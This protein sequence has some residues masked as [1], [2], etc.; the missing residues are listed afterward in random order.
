[1]KAKYKLIALASFTLAFAGLAVGVPLGVSAEG[2]DEAVQSGGGEEEAVVTTLGE[3]TTALK[4]S[5]RPVVKLGADIELDS[6]ILINGGR[7]V[8]IDLNGH[9]ITTNSTADLIAIYNAQV[10]V[11]GT[12]T[13]GSDTTASPFYVA[14]TNTDVA[15]FSKLTVGENVTLKADDYAIWVGKGIGSFT[16]VYGASIDFYGKID[17]KYGFYINGTIQ[18][19]DGNVA[20]FNIHDGAEIKTT[21]HYTYAAGYGHWTFDK[22]TIVAGEG[23]GLKAGTFEYNGTTVTTTG[24]YA[25]PQSWNNGINNSGAT[26]QIESNDAYADNVK[27]VVNGGTYISQNGHVFYEYK[28]KEDTK[29]TVREVVIK[30][31]EFVAGDNR[32]VF[33]VSDGF[34]LTKFI[35]GGVFSDEPAED[36]IADGYVAVLEKDNFE[37]INPD[38]LDPADEI[39]TTVVDG[40]EVNIVVP[41][42]IDWSGE[43]AIFSD[44]A[45]EDSVSGRVVFAD[46]MVADRLA[47]IVILD[48]SD[49]VDD[50]TVDATKTGDLIKAFDVSMIDRN[51][52]EIEVKDNTIRVYIDLTEDEYSALAAYN[53]V[54]V[55][56]FDDD[57][58]EAERLDAEIYEE[59]DASG[60]STYVLAFTTSHFSTYGV[61][62][63]NASEDDS[64][65]TTTVDTPDTGTVTASGASAMNASIVA[66]V[67]VGLITTVFGLA[68][69]FKRARE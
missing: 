12:G 61:V 34:S 36:Y 28:A 8:E 60:V 69:V 25:E 67:A 29:N 56:Y 18:N 23:I 7:I 40:E 30:D 16:S 44:I 41:K 6:R 37:V 63:V 49:E 46:E 15:D 9:N 14:A 65:E 43:S 59:T 4:D 35:S 3:F 2:S 39:I 1:M 17:S 47:R 53:K 57:G 19:T 20:T 64:T 68:V 21:G 22:A 10:T 5:T 13:I 55:V 52:A 50:L 66:A 11:S 58:N 38:E 31:G 48:K 42:Q 45:D 62:G 27:I 54:A 32:A 24:A 26:F 51:G 33:Q